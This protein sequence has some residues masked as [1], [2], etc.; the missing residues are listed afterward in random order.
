VS[1]PFSQDLTARF[2]RRESDAITWVYNEY[3]SFVY[4]IV[5]KIISRSADNKDL[6]ADSFVKLLR[7]EGQF[8]SPAKIKF[9]LYTAAKNTC[10][11]YLRHLKTQHK[12]EFDIQEQWMRDLKYIEEVTETTAEF[13]RLVF[14]T[15]Q[16]L[17]RKCRQIFYLYYNNGLKNSEIAALLGISVKTV[18]NQKN[19]A[20]KILKLKLSKMKT[21]SLSFFLIGIWHFLNLN[22]LLS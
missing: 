4:S 18:S 19:L 13:R 14:E 5:R 2:N 7:Y 20:R 12:K 22:Y 16:N 6:V 21:V 1:I 15:I 11:D 17:P 3:Y 10:L 8:Q 9:F